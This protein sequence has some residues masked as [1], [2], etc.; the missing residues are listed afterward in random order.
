MEGEKIEYWKWEGKRLDIENGRG[1]DWIL[2]MGGEKF[3]STKYL[4]LSCPPSC[5]SKEERFAKCKI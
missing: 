1:K 4:Q 3:P 2:K 5:I